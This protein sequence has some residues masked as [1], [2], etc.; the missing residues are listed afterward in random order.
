MTFS[1]KSSVITALAF[2]LLIFTSITALAQEEEGTEAYLA[3]ARFGCA[4]DITKKHPEYPNVPKQTLKNINDDCRCLVDK[5]FEKYGK[6]KVPDLFIDHSLFNEI[7]PICQD[8]GYL[9]H[10]K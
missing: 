10:L 7:V 6:D 9:Q 5:T 8:M 2:S 3:G 4:Y 1:N